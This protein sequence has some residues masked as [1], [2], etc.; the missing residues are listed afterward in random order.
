MNKAS[1]PELQYFLC[2]IIYAHGSIQVC[3]AFSPKP[4]SKTQKLNIFNYYILTALH[5][6]LRSLLGSLLGSLLDLSSFL[7]CFL[8][9][10]CY[11][12]A[13]LCSSAFRSG[14][15]AVAPWQRDVAPTQEIS[16]VGCRMMSLFSKI[17]KVDSTCAARLWKVCVS[18]ISGGSLVELQTPPASLHKFEPVQNSFRLTGLRSKC[19]IS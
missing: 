11:A 8:F 2:D 6:L 1:V 14:V 18:S 16:A 3:S 10:N 12:N 19:I 9:A 15:L 13:M 4:T 7:L 17:F 5:C